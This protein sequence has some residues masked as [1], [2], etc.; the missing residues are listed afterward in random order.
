[1][2]DATVAVIGAGGTMGFGMARNIARA[3]MSVVAWDRSREKA[4]PLEQD[5]AQICDTAAQATARADVIVTMLADADAVV[6]TMSGAGALAAARD[7]CVWAQMATIGEDGTSRCIELASERGIALV[8]APVLGT[9][10]PAAEGKLVVMASGPEDARER[11]Q[12]VFDAVGQRTMW[13]G[14]AGGGT[15]LKLVTN[16]WLVSVVEGLAETLALADGLGLDGRLFFEAI[17]GQALDMAYARLKGRAMLE[18]DFEP[19]FALKHATKDAKLAVAAAQRLDLDLPVLRAIA[20]RMQQA[21][22]D[23]GDEDLSATYLTSAPGDGASP[24]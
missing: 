10:Q 18:R 19:T 20:E 16:A 22:R 11:V 24:R 9:K 8:D 12:P 4:E 7:D 1:M 15:R 6:Q 13:I 23:H 14:E 21:V 3:G 17:E 2:A 5:G